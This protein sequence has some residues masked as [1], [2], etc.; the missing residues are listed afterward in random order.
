MKHLASTLLAT[1]TALAWAPMT[2]AARRPVA[3]A[4]GLGLGAAAVQAGSGEHPLAPLVGGFGRLALGRH[5]YLEAEASLARRAEGG[6]LAVFDERWTRGAA[7]LGCSAGTHATRVAASLGPAVTWR[8]SSL[9]AEERW[10]AS[11]L[12]PG[13]RYRTGFLIPVKERWQVDLLMGGS[14][15]GWVLDSDLILQAGVRW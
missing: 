2:H 11:S 10:Q 15:R 3:S 7:G 14:S 1:L 13:L 5:C 12:R 4:A 6:D 8:S 9:Q